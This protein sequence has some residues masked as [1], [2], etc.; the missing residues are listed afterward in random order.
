MLMEV[1][2]VVAKRGV[3]NPTFSYCFVVVWDNLST[4]YL[5]SPDMMSNMLKRA[6]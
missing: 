4:Y 6:L 2:S 3:D 1:G 5:A